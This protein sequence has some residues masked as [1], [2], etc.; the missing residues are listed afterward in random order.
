MDKLIKW[1]NSSKTLNEKDVK[2]IVNLPYKLQSSLS[3][4]VSSKIIDYCR[5]YPNGYLADYDHHCKVS[6]YYH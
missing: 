3:S 4:S 6:D 5:V 1:S 2:M